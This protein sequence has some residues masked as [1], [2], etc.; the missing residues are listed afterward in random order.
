MAPTNRV[1]QSET[2]TPISET[3]GRSLRRLSSLVRVALISLGAGAILV[4][5]AMFLKDS[6]S[7]RNW[8]NAAGL[9]L[10]SVT[11]VMLFLAITPLLNAQGVI[12]R[13]TNLIDRLQDATIEMTDI[14]STL[15]ALLLKQATRI[16]EVVQGLRSQIR[17]I[18]GH[19]ADHLADDAGLATLDRLSSDV[20]NIMHNS[21]NTIGGFRTAIAQS[22]PAEL[23]KCL[24]ELASVRDA[25]KRLM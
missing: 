8:L 20:V 17:K 14:A 3:I 10:I 22:N 6:N 7:A 4:L 21:N 19:F 2:I 25:I 12:Q 9:A 15:N 5:V 1:P 11:G 24:S 13:N 16:A 23:N 18:P